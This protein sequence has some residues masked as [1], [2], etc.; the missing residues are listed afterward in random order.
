MRVSK[1]IS[2]LFHPIFIP[3]ITWIITLFFFPSI[4]FMISSY[5]S[6]ITQI[7]ILSTIIIPSMLI[8]FL[9][10]KKK[11]TSLEMS[12]YQERPLPLI[13]SALIIFLGYLFIHPFIIF[14]PILKAQFIGAI[15]IIL[16]AGFIS[17]CWKISLHMLAIGGLT[18]AITGASFLLQEGSQLI[19]FLILISGVL[20]VSRLNEKAH[21]HAQIYTG[22][23]I[24][25]IIECA[26]VFVI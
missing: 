12:N 26:G 4:Y 10:K 3:L 8:L 1:I 22:F 18:G 25:F 15:I 6:F 9:L 7:I 13:L 16:I 14:S 5:I 17:I 23:L 19:L 21:N 11:I 24:G 20:G 2:I